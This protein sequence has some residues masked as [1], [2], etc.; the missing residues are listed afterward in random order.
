MNEHR[1][2]TGEAIW[3]GL[4]IL[5]LLVTAGAGAFGYVQYLALRDSERVRNV[6]GAALQDEAQKRHEATELSA[7]LSLK[8][9]DL[10]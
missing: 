7:D 6:I 10:E 5:L 2:S 3:I 9:R 1:S 4:C 8:V